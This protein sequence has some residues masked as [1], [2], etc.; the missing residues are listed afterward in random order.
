MCYPNG[1]DTALMGTYGLAVVGLAG[2]SV[3]AA[4]G[5]PMLWWPAKR[6]VDVRLMGAWLLAVSAIIAVIS[7][8]L[9]GLL[10]ATAGVNHAINLIGLVANPLVYV[11]LLPESEQRARIARLW[12]LWLPAATYA[13]MVLTRGAFGLTTRV[14]FAWLL[15]VVLTFTVLCAWQVIRHRRQLPTR[16]VR[17]E[18]VVAFLVVV[19]V[20]QMVRMFFGHL[21]LVP[22]I[23]PLAVTGGFVV[24]VGIV[25]ARSIGG[26]LA[27]SSA[28]A[29]TAPKYAKSNLDPDA[30]LSLLARIDQT[31]G[32]DRL[33]A[34]PALTLGRLAAAAGTTPHQVSEVL[35]RYANVTFHDLLNRRRVAD[36]KAQLLDPASDRYTIEGIGASAGFG[37]RSA[38]YAAFRRLEGMT[39]AQFRERRNA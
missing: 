1:M 38:M 18:W 33:F 29:T 7:A 24:L 25:A 5:V 30:A 14:P 27:V 10:P 2:S 13:A 36:V 8:R 12:W 21:P 31:L 4:L 6:P 16:V 3:G 34:D 23:V 19:N 15:P 11:Y 26:E 22:A 35:N 28:G 37:S 17:P 32:H 9:L 39:P 20:A